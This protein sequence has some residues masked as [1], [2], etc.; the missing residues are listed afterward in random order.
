MNTTATTLQPLYTSI[1]GHQ[2]Q[3]EIIT[4][5]H[6][7]ICNNPNIAFMPDIG[8]I[9]DN[10]CWNIRC[11][12]LEGEICIPLGDRNEE[13]IVRYT[14]RWS[15]AYDYRQFHRLF[16]WWWSHSYAEALTESDFKQAFGNRMGEHYFEK[17]RLYE[18]SIPRMIGYFGADMHNGQLFLNLMARMVTR[19]ETHIKE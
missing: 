1:C 15:I 8:P 2:I 18:R 9:K 3:I 10:L 19:Y 17:W 7:A 5:T 4:T 6:P 14:A 16:R 13:T 11:G 12:R